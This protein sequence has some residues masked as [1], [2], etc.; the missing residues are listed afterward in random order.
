MQGPD[1][2]VLKT[3]DKVN[4][5]QKKNCVSGRHIWKARCEQG[6]YDMFPLLADFMTVNETA[7]DVIASTI[8]NHLQQLSHYF[9]VYFGDNDTSMID[10]I[11]NLFECLLTDLI[12][13]EQDKLA[14]LSSD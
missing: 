11:R 13:R 3:H 8:L 1:S 7:T 14:E 12:G 10:W 2:Y 4:A 6:V 9:Y 5:F